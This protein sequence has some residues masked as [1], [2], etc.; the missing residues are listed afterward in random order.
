M[1]AAISGGMVLPPVLGGWEAGC[2]FDDDDGGAAGAGREASA[3]CGVVL[4]VVVEEEGSS[5]VV[6]LGAGDLRLRLRIC[7]F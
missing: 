7:R 1:A 5:V 4:A 3:G 6:L 2:S